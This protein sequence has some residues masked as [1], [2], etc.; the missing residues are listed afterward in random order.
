VI[1]GFRREE[2]ICALLGCY[3]AYGGNSLPTFRDN[4]LGPSSRVKKSKILS[5]FC[6]SDTNILVLLILVFLKK[7]V[8]NYYILKVDMKNPLMC[9]VATTIITCEPQLNR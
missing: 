1:S 6:A 2:E 5:A 9:I 4:L 7:K 3:T 8:P